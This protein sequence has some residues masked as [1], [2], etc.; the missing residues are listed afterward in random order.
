MPS[1][2]WL[3]LTAIII[4]LSISSTQARAEV[5]PGV[6]QAVKDRDARFADAR[7]AWAVDVVAVKIDYAKQLN[8]L[9]EIEMRRGNLEGVLAA[10]AEQARIEKD[11]APTQKTTRFVLSLRSA[12]DAKIAAATARYNKVGLQIANEFVSALD[13]VIRDETMAGRI[14]VALDIR[15]TRTEFLEDGI[16]APNVTPPAPDLPPAPPEPDPEPPAAGEEFDINKAISTSAQVKIL[17][18]SPVELKADMPAFP[19]VPDLFVKNHAVIYAERKD[20]YNGVAD[21]KVLRSGYL[22]LACYYGYQGNSSGN[23]T[24]TRWTA[25]DFVKNGWKQL[26]NEDVGGL[27]A[28]EGG[29]DQTLF[30]K[31]VKKGEE[32]RLRCNK[33]EPPYA[34]IFPVAGGK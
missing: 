13:E 6:E 9:A 25:E 15:K 4:C 19:R 24:E 32:M 10:K 18:V 1:V 8:R 26:T 27:L 7:A 14:Q 29:R 21:I 34:I 31:W 33:Y 16:P 23:W 12:Y 30:V 17:E 2:Q 5:L 3:R 20:K 28:R 11:A 22:I